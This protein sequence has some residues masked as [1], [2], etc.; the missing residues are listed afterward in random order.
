MHS[1]TDRTDG[2]NAPAPKLMLIGI[3]SATWHVMTPLIE[4]G[5]LPNLGRLI[6]EGA[7]G[8]LRTFFPTLSPLVWST[9]S[10][11]KS[12]EKHG[13]KSFATLKIPG[14]RRTLYDYRW[15]Q[16][17][18]FSRFVH[19]VLRLKWWKK[20]LIERGVIKRIP[21][22]SN[23]RRCK[24]VWNIA[25][26]WERRV[27]FVGWWN[28]WPA[29]RVNGFWISQYVELLLSAPPDALDRAT[30]PESAF[31]DA[32]QYL[33]TDGQMT[34]QEVTRFFNLNGAELDSLAT[35]RPSKFPTQANYTPLQFLKLEYLCHEFRRRATRHFYLQHT[36]HLLG[37]FLSADPAQHFFWHCMEPEHF[38][39]VPNQDIARYRQTIQNWYGYLD[40]IV[41][42]FAQLQEGGTVAIV[43][44]HGHGPSG[45]LPW[46]G[47]HDDAPDGIIILSGR[48]IRRGATIDNASVYDVT[49]T[50]LAL[51]GLPVGRDMEGKILSEVIAPE[52]LAQ[53]PIRTVET[54]EVHE[55]GESV[56][57]ES[58]ADELV[59]QRLKDLG[60]IE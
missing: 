18:P 13:M 35:F 50:V 23:F 52:F 49:P 39:H 42:E 51:M 37:V 6:R 28:S 5:E 16:L 33:R 38:E 57:I 30:Y 20:R 47:Q 45:T 56:A 17:T 31:Y 58:S 48:A 40:E 26:D 55:R 19:R 1:L 11:G 32:L 25:S 8:P 4:R 54:H 46:S 10:T 59:V 3:D 43:S 22:T 34:P 41:G 7:H 29:E 36:P 12:P 60:Y 14:L 53:F 9:I 15:E 44:D 24:A 27:G 2:P 21:L